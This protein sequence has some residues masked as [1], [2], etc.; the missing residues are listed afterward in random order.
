MSNHVIQGDFVVEIYFFMKKI[1]FS[2]N[3]CRHS[4]KSVITYTQR[5]KVSIRN[6]ALSIFI[7]KSFFCVLS[8]IVTP[9]E[10]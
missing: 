2:L 3:S 5:C 8:F 9:V 7:E 4:H 10:R 6:I 1:F